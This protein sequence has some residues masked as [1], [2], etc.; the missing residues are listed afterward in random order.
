MRVI[1]WAEVCSMP[2]RTASLIDRVRHFISGR[3][4]YSQ[5]MV[6]KL[7]EKTLALREKALRYRHPD[8]LSS[9]YDVARA[10]YDLG[11]YDDAEDL[12]VQ[13]Y[14]LY[15]REFGER[16]PKTIHALILRADA[17]F[18]NGR[19]D[20]A[21][22]LL[23][24]ATDRYSRAG[25]Y[26]KPFAQ[27]M[28]HRAW[29]RKRQG[30]NDGA[31]HLALAA[32]EILQQH[33]PSRYYIWCMQLVAEVYIYRMNYSDA[34]S[35]LRPALRDSQKT[36]VAFKT[37]FD[38]MFL[39]AFSHFYLVEY[40]EAEFVVKK[41]VNEGKNMLGAADSRTLQAQILLEKIQIA[42]R[43]IDDESEPGMELRE[44]ADIE[45]VFGIMPWTILHLHWLAHKRFVQQCSEY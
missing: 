34:V 42:I 33:E 38:I 30:D 23:S 16:S 32:K 10:H 25:I 8:T 1:E 3:A 6:L 24:R 40:D 5:S 13:L 14:P 45:N 12:A 27:A 29:M 19:W 17:T 9:M 43:D 35:T 22:Q 4:G 31:L 28:Y 41:A 2:D 26:D 11:N 37:T 44:A 7:A 21:E 39:L 15:K 20:E 36:F 18:R